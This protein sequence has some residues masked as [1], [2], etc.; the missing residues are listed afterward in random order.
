MYPV[1]EHYLEDIL[2]KLGKHQYPHRHR[3]HEVR[4]TTPG[5]GAFLW[6]PSSLSS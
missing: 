6:I 5:S 3:H 2:A 1:K 4:D